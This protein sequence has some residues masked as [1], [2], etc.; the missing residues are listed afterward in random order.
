MTAGTPE[1]QSTIDRRWWCG[2]VGGD[3]AADGEG[4]DDVVEERERI[5]EERSVD[6]DRP[7]AQTGAGLV[8]DE[9]RERAGAVAQRDGQAELV[10]GLRV[11]VAE[12]GL[13]GAL[14]LERSQLFGEA[15]ELEVVEGW[16]VAEVGVPDLGVLTWQASALPSRPVL[17]CGNS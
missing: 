17:K 13:S 7:E 5:G 16:A 14:A 12:D 8:G 10:A 2:S 6:V 11:G 1:R 3:V 15:R 4:L 9:A